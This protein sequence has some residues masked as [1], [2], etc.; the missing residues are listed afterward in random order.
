MA[1]CNSLVNNFVVP[2]MFATR[3]TAFAT[4]P[5]AWGLISAFPLATAGFLGL[6]FVLTIGVGIVFG[7]A[8]FLS[9]C[10]IVGCIPFVGAY[11][12]TVA[13]LPLWIFLYCFTIRYIEQFGPEYKI[14]QDGFSAPAP[15]GMYGDPEEPYWDSRPNPPDAPP[16]SGP[17]GQAYPTFPE[18]DPVPPPPPSPQPPAYPPPPPPVQ[19]GPPPFPPPPPAPAPGEEPQG[20]PPGQS[21][22]SRPPFAPPPIPPPDDGERRE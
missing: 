9:F 19:G 21:P 6:R 5:R 2:V 16:R 17:I 7:C 3:A 13:T 18:D 1:L 4:V 14:I 22:P 10:L 12:V 20:P 8:S 15:P 11:L